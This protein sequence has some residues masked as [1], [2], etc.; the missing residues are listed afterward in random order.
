MRKIY[1]SESGGEKG[2]YNVNEPWSWLIVVVSNRL[3]VILGIV[4][5]LDIHS[6]CDHGLETEG[7]VETWP[8]DDCF[9]QPFPSKCT[10]T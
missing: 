2:I 1:I 3:S 7:G 10:G 5:L 4:S 6:R 8:S 9:Q